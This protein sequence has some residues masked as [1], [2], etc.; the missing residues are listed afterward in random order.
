MVWIAREGNNLHRVIDNELKTSRFKK[1]MRS[2]ASRAYN[3]A[4][5]FLTISKEQARAFEEDRNFRTKSRQTIYNGVDLLKVAEMS[6]QK[7]EVPFNAPFIISIGR[8]DEQKGYDLLLEAYAQSNSY[9]S[10]HL[11]LLGSGPEEKK[12]KTLASQLGIA[13][14][15]HF[16]G[17]KSN[18]WAWMRRA[19][20]FV[21]SSYWEG[22]GNVVIESMACGTPPI[23][24]DCD[25]G[26]REIVEHNQ[27]G[28]IFRSRD[29]KALI[30]AIDRTLGDSELLERLRKGAQQRALAFCMRNITGYDYSSV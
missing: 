30:Q 24:S 19:D 6:L 22:F 15:V 17:F 12:L 10:H 9:S 27:S 20:A 14:R 26:P 21:L 5:C 3:S 23:V 1:F 8:L 2:V 18:P 28:L 11:V 25:F 13:E 7:V 4:D 29:R 16:L